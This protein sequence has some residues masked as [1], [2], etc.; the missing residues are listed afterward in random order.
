MHV[1]K[2]ICIYTR[3]HA[4]SR[5]MHKAPGYS[6]LTE[7]L[8]FPCS[9]SAHMLRLLQQWDVIIWCAAGK[10]KTACPCVGCYEV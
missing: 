9:L 2:Y 3:I 7:Q 10:V 6:G 4:D 5:N 8:P 1:Y